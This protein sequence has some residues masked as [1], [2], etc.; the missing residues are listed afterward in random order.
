[1]TSKEYVRIKGIERAKEF[2]AKAMPVVGDIVV[3]RGK[4]AVDGKSLLGVLSL[5]LR[6]GVTVIYP[7]DATNFAEYLTSIKE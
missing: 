1:M 5:D 4:F 7:S 2:V 3:T 6:E